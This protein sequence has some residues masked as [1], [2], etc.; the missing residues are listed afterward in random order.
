MNATKNMSGKA[1]V[2]CLVGIFGGISLALVQNKVSP[3]ITV[4]MSVFDINM[5]TAGLLSTIFTFVGIIMALPAAMILKRFGPKKSGVAALLFAVVGSIIGITTDNIAVLI[6]SRVIEGTGIGIIAVLAPSLISMWF[7]PEK[8]GFPMGIWGSWM[9]ISQTVLFFS[10]APISEA[11]GWQGMWGL[12][13]GACIIAAIL[14]LLF[15][16]SPKTEVSHAN[17]ESKEVSIIEGLKSRGSFTLAIAAACFTF[18]SFT[19]V[20]WISAY[21]GVATSWSIEEIGRWVA[22]L[23]LIEMVYAWIIG[24]ILNR[25]KNRKLFGAAGFVFYG[26]LGLAAFMITGEPIIVVFV[27]VFPVFDALIPCVCWTIAPETATKPM[28]A[29]I[30]L[31]ILNIGLNLG[32]LLSAP[33][34]GALVESYGWIAAGLCFLVAAI[35]GAVAMAATKLSSAAPEPSPEFSPELSPEIAA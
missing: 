22:I 17:V 35:I 24:G 11:F 21:W 16:E 5:S 23:Y 30:A 3:I 14:F 32:T 15:V 7:P 34:S 12:G 27:F 25:V 18:C 4:L 2:V 28:Y 26:L 31:G 6:V 1:W 19:F 20:S 9:M 10:A 8:R 29:G 13:L 33:V